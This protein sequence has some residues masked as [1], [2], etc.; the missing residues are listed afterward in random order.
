MNYGYQ[1]ELDFVELFNNKY[2]YELDVNSQKF[3]KELFEVDINN[4]EVIKSWKNKM[5]QKT[6]IFIKYGNKIKNISLKCGNSNSMHHE[7]IQ[8]FERY[9]HKIGIP[10]NIINI[11]LGY[12]YGYKKSNDG[13]IDYSKRL[14]SEQYKELYQDEINTFNYAINKTKIIIDMVDRFVIRGRN[15]DYDIDALICGTIDDYVWIMKYDLYDLI[16]SKR[17]LNFT[18][19]HIACMT[20]GPKKRNLDG[21][22]NNRKDRYQLC[23]RWN[24][25]REDI[26]YF[27]KNKFDSE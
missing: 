18:S 17:C 12:H 2:L 27:R 23:V 25:I 1:N 24:F 14:S 26:I 20:L 8:E 22:S 4:D 16:L 19:P 5:L 9:L 11:Y 7:Q 15:S 6:D 3:L 10:Y 21:N 13:I